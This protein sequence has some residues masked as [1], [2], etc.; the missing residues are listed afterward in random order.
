M[1]DDDDFS[2]SCFS[3]SNA[4]STRRLASDASK[5]GRRPFR[6]TPER[7]RSNRSSSAFAKRGCHS[8]RLVLNSVTSSSLT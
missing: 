1:N 4:V 5:S 3:W 8:A 2:A 7:R 6:L